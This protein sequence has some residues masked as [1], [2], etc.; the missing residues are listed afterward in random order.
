L[1]FLWCSISERPHHTHHL[2]QQANSFLPHH[3]PRSNMCELSHSIQPCCLVLNF[4]S[5]CYFVCKKAPAPLALVL[6]WTFFF[7]NHPLHSLSVLLDSIFTR[8]C[9]RSI[10]SAPAAHCQ[11][12]CRKS[13]TRTSATTRSAPRAS[14]TGS[15]TRARAASDPCFRRAA[16]TRRLRF[17]ATTKATYCRTCARLRIPFPRPR[18][19]GLFPVVVDFSM[20]PV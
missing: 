20:R 15:P 11:R 7:L 18:R 6:V 12:P 10:F 8:S 1:D 5:C 16:R 14:A 2:T 4:L 17:S 19:Y 9:N 3:S 13:T